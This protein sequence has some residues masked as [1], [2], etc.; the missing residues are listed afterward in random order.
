[1]SFPEIHC[2]RIGDHMLYVGI[3]INSLLWTI[4][5][6]IKKPVPELDLVSCE[7]EPQILVWKQDYNSKG[8]TN[9]LWS[10]LRP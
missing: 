3:F 9:L 8:H 5:Y 4:V 1:M 7:P 2:P 10:C 6:E